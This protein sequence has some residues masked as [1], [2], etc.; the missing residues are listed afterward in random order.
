LQN[1]FSP[2]LLKDNNID[3]ADFTD[4]NTYAI[5]SLTDIYLFSVKEIHNEVNYRFFYFELV[6]WLLTF[7]VI[8]I[9]IQN[10]CF[11][12]ANKGH[13]LLS[14][15]LLALFIV[16]VRFVNLQY[17]WPNFTYKLEIFNPKLYTANKVFPSLGDLCINILMLELVNRLP[18]PATF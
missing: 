9:F 8:C 1:T 3:I 11:Y 18:L 12:L 6:I 13:L 17:N 2:D 10:I 4:G 16:G 15:L 7:V 5:H 14:F